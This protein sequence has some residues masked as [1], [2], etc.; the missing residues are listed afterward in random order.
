MLTYAD[1]WYL[2][3]DA[4]RDPELLNDYWNILSNDEISRGE[5]FCFDRDRHRHL[6]TWALAR[7]MLSSYADISPKAWEFGNNQYGRPHI[8]GPV[9]AP[10]LRFNL[11]HTRN[12][13]ACIV[14]PEF[15][16]G[17]DVE[18]CRR[19]ISGPAIARRYFSARE[20]AAFE[21]LT[22][23]EQAA[24]FFEYWTLKEA[25][26]KAVGR[27]ISL[28]LARFSFELDDRSLRVDDP[29]RRPPRISF[30][31]LNDDPATWQFA[32]Y[33]PTPHHAMAIAIRCGVGKG[34]EIRLKEVGPNLASC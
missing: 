30:D 23:N 21:R 8:S 14:A 9:S 7:T 24:A 33:K 17:I 13:I 11:S 16:V 25:Y 2:F 22:K 32:Q 27:G 3:P 20:V 5:R 1:V 15:D 18:D 6:V 34:L 4:I 19:N 28:G 29:E 31:G 26:V 12:L 10:N